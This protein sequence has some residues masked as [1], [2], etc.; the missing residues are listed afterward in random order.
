MDSIDPALLDRDD[1]RAALAARD[2]GAVCRLLWQA[3]VSQRQ[4]AQLTGQS[5]SEVC[6][7]LKGRQVRDV[8]VLERIADG[9]GAPRAW[10]GLSYGEEPD[11][12]SVE[13]DVDED[14]KRRALIAATSVAA[15]GQ[16]IQGL[17]KPIE[18]ALPTGQVLPSRLGMSHVHAV[19]A[20]TERLVSVTRHYGGQAD[21]FAAAAR[22]YT[23]WMEVP[24]TEAIEARLAAAL[25]DLHTQAGRACYDSGVDGRGH[26]T[27]AL[28]LAD[29]AGDAYGIANAAWEAG[30][31]LVR[32]GHPNDALKLFQLG[33]LHL[34]GFRKSTPATLRTN[35]PRLPIL[36]A[37]LSR[38]SA[39]AYALLDRPNQATRCLAEACDG[40]AP[41]DAFERAGGDFVTAGVQL[42]LGQLDTAEQ[43]A[44]SAVRTYGANHRRDRT[45]A[46]LLLAEVHVRAGEAHGL[47]LARDAI[48]E[49]STLQS[50]A[51]RRARLVPLAAA[52]E[53]RPGSDTREL[54]RTARK[55]AATRI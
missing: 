47:S 29:Q 17:G 25:A 38:Q 53:A 55:G 2:I 52:L 1:V 43:L 36:T 24:A 49:V 50:V 12:P 42:D 35:D 30:M 23:R 22:L 37:R 27:R 41:R 13:R 51:A 3:G 20:V 7:I 14:M 9:L 8:W 45:Q 33:Q 18:L 4:I 46:Q 21:L 39:T 54:A 44:A 11:S 5:Q 48:E 34:G 19:R 32:S 16:V 10:M 40:W 15:L 26:F 31:T 28:R 6:E